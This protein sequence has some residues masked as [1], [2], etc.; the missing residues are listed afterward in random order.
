VYGGAFA[1]VENAVLDTASVGGFAHLTAK[2][3]NFPH[4]TALSRTS[5]GRVAGHISHSVK[6]CGKTNNRTT[7]AVSRQRGFNTRMAR[8]DYRNVKRPH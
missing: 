4:Q 6:L 8:A 1:A 3:V 2:S 5:D 7:Q